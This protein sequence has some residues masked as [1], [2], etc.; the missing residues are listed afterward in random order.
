MRGAGASRIGTIEEESCKARDGRHLLAKESRWPRN[1][2]IGS[3]LARR[4]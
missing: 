1:W 4:D 2:A 3:R